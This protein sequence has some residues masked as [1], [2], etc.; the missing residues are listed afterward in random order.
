MT[1]DRIQAD[2]R[3]LPDAGAP[4]PADTA[5]PAVLDSAPSKPRIFSGIQPSG[6]VHLGNDRWR[7]ASKD[8]YAR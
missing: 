6:I 2:A 8:A 5:S 4:A 1:T 3:A 7:A